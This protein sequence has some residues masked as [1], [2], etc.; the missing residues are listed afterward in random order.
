MQTHGHGAGAAP[1]GA[2]LAPF[3]CSPN[4]RPMG[5]DNGNG[6]TVRRLTLLGV[7]VSAAVALTGFTDFS[8]DDLG[9]LAE[10]SESHARSEANADS[11]RG[12][13]WAVERLDRTFRIYACGDDALDRTARIRLRCGELE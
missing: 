3:S 11:I 5:D 13:R 2:V 9:A 4:P 6:W 12:V 8:A 1:K 10:A 7:L